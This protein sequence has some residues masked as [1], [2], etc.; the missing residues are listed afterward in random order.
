MTTGPLL[1]VRDLGVDFS[2]SQGDV[3]AVSGVS[4]DVHA[5]EC[6]AVVGES[7]S[8]KTQVLMACLG[9][10]TWHRH[11][12]AV[13]RPAQFTHAAPA[14]RDVVD[15]GPARSRSRHSRCSP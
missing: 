14:H 5:G 7:G 12:P 1:Q 9:H 8:G 15:R 11:R 10:D 13:A 2:T 4:F 3:Q 6:L